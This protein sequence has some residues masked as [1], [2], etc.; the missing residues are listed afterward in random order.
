MNQCQV[1]EEYREE[2]NNHNLICGYC[3]AYVR[4]QFYDTVV[5]SSQ[6]LNMKLSSDRI[7]QVVNAMV[8]E[9]L[10]SS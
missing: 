10:R 6:N 8:E 9:L 3:E 5:T 4:N 2:E 1:C 7:N